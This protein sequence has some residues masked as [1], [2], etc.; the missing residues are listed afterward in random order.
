MMRV[1]VVYDSLHGNT[2]AVAEAIGGAM[3]GEVAV[4]HVTE[5]ETTGLGAYD[6]VVVGAPTH[7]GRPSD[8][9][10]GFLAKVQAPALQ[11]VRVAGFD[12]RLTSRWVR[13]FGYAAP[14]IAKALEAAGGTLAGPPGDFYVTGGEGPL[15]EGELA[16]AVAWARAVQGRRGG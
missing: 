11:G 12:T 5:V 6:L 16:R 9:A 10:K 14:R 13:I 3:A 2:K 8:P 4:R 7:G 1:L 15:R